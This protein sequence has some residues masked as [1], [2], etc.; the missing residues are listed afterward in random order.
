MADS[1]AGAGNI[2][3]WTVLCW[4]DRNISKRFRIQLDRYSTS[5]IEDNLNIKIND[6]GRDYNSLNKIGT[7]ECINTHIGVLTVEC[8]LISVEEMMELENCCLTTDS[9]KIHQ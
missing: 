1:E 9:D 2:Q 3:A 6:D 7:H 8:Q 4:S 5:Q